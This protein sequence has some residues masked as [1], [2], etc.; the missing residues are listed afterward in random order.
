MIYKLI[1]S[2]QMVLED[3][4]RH[5]LKECLIMD[6]YLSAVN[7][8]NRQVLID[9]HSIVGY[10]KYDGHP[11]LMTVSDYKTHHCANKKCPL[12]QPYKSFPYWKKHKIELSYFQSDPALKK[13]AEEEKERKRKQA[14]REENKRQK[15]KALELQRRQEQLE[16]QD[17]IASL[18]VYIEQL[19]GETSAYEMFVAKIEY[20]GKHRYKVFLVSTYDDYYDMS[21][22]PYVIENLKKVYPG[23]YTF[24]RMK[25]PY[26]NFATVYEWEHRKK[27]M[28]GKA[29]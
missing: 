21:F 12:F 28:K 4:S 1:E 22:L 24:Q 29:V 11:G 27:L 3:P 6:K 9:I 8:E 26:G 7:N 16:Q 13:R 2:Q 20:L 14:E 18:K 19:F 10:C 17:R 23:K 5:F 25:S 15:A